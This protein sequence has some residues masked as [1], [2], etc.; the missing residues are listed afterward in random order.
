MWCL[1]IV[2]VCVCV[3]VC[4]PYKDVEESIAERLIGLTEMVP[5]RVWSVAARTLSF[6][7]WFVRRGAWVLGTSAALLILPVFIEQQRVEFEEMQNMQKKQVRLVEFC[8]LP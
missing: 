2:C 5:G 4:V 7:Y 6:S 8:K 1:L 3:C